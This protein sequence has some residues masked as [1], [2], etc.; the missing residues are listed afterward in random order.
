MLQ[1]EVAFATLEQQQ[2]ISLTVQDDAT[3]NDAIV[4]S[5]ISQYFQEYDILNLPVGIFGKRIFDAAQYKLQDGD[6]IE[7]Y[8]PL[9]KSPNQQRLARAKNS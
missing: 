2:V 4:A 5:Q 9:N 8:R 6:R 3:I 7:I 1:I